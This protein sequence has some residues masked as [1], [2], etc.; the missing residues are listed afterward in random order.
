PK[1]SKDYKP[2]KL[3]EILSG[4]LQPLTDE[5]LRP[6]SEAIEEMDKTKEKIEK[7]QFDVKQLANLLI[8]YGNYNETI[9]Y[10][11]AENYIVSLTEKENKTKELIFLE[12]EINKINSELEEE[13][14]KMQQLEIEKDNLETK[15]ANIDSKDLD[16]KINRLTKLEEELKLEQERKEK[17]QTDLNQHLIKVKDMEIDLSNLNKE[18]DKKEVETKKK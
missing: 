6:L 5:D 16:S 8:T 9:L 4:V 14:N 18:K 3:M 13:Q 7:I 1:L 15:R 10:K 17:I 11:K 12:Q 2:T